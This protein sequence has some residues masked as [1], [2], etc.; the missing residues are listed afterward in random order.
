MPPLKDVRVEIKVRNN[1]LLSAM[2]ARGI[3]SL[4]QLARMVGP[5]SYSALC[6]MAAMKR[7]ARLKN[8]EWRKLA[9]QVANVLQCM[10][11]DLFSE[12]QQWDKLEK[13]RAKAEISFAEIQ[14]LAAPR[15]SVSTPEVQLVATELRNQI[16]KALASLTPREEFVIRARFGFVDGTEHTFEQI[17]ARLGFGI[18]RA[19]QIE[20]KALRKLMHPA[21]SKHLLAAGAGDFTPE[22]SWQ[23]RVKFDPEVL[24]A[25]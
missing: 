17:G 18:E 16:H 2:E 21:R 6:A 8:G 4:G 25:L 5:G 9:L 24:E 1:L 22:D 15:G 19:R 23:R 20:A 11:E 7:P 3:S 12:P 10:P 13:N 14:Q